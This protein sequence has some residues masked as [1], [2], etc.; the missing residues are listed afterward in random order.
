MPEE[1]ETE[2][3]EKELKAE[4][5]KLAET[6]V[7]DGLGAKQLGLLYRLAK[8]KPMPFV[9]AFVQKQIGRGVRGFIPDFGPTVLELLRRYEEDKASLQKVLMYANMLYDY[10]ERRQGPPRGRVTPSVYVPTGGV[11]AVSPSVRVAVE[12]AARGVVGQ[13]YEGLQV[14]E[15]RGTTVFTVRARYRGNPRELA[16]QVFERIRETVPEAS[17]L[18]F[19]VW[20][21][22]L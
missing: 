7:R 14:S 6:A 1:K 4:G 20:I 9:E 3:T 11:A 15:M 21:E 22:Q 5:E 10:C 19:R 2:G 8:T 17:R 18:R 13:G 12:A 16:S